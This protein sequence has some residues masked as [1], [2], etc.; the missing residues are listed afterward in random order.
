MTHSRTGSCTTVQEVELACLHQKHT[1]G[2]CRHQL[3]VDR[4]PFISIS[5]SSRI[6]FCRTI[7]PSL[8]Y[9]IGFSCL[10]QRAME[11]FFGDKTVAQMRVEE[12]NEEADYGL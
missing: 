7:A 12:H 10:S 4:A 8:E 5:I 6:H 2:V 1:Q 9:L 11:G 3:V